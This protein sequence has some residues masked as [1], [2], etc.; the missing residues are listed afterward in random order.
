M[1]EESTKDGGDEV[2][3]PMKGPNEVISLVENCNEEDDDDA[4][5]TATES[6]DDDESGDENSQYSYEDDNDGK[7]V[8]MPP[9]KYARIMGSL[10]RDSASTSTALT[11]KITCSAM[12]RVVVRPS[13]YSE[14]SHEPSLPSGSKHGE[15]AAEWTDYDDD[16]EA[17]MSLTKVHHVLAF[18]F[19]DG[20]VRLV[21]ALTGGSVLFGSSSGDGGAWFVNPAAAKR[22]YDPGHKIV[23]LSFDSSSSYLS[24]LNANGDA[25]IFGPLVW[26]KQSQRAQ[27]TVSGGEGQQRLGFLAS[28][29]GKEPEPTN[30]SDGARFLRPAFT[31][32]KPPAS[33]VRCTYA[34][35]Q[36]FGSSILGGG[37]SGGGQGYH[38]TCMAL[39]PSYGRRKE[40]ALIVGF[41]DG[42]LILSKLQGA[43]G[44]G[45]GITSL[46]GGGGSAA[47]GG[48]TVKKVDSVL[49]QGM[50]STSF[51]GD[52]AG[53]EAVTWR[54][55][56][57]AWAD[58]SG[59]RLFD[60]E[61]MSRIAH[62]DKPTGAR[63]SLYPTISSLH[64]S[65][66]FER[67]DLLLI[68]WG[69]CLMALRV[70]DTQSLTAAT[71]D[72]APAKEIKRKTVEATMAWELDCVACSV[73]P[74]DKQ[75]VAVLGL[76]PS[77]SS[78][79]D[80]DESDQCAKSNTPV[81]DYSV[82]GGD[83]VLELQIINRETGKSI[84]NDRL[85]LSEGHHQSQGD[86]L[87]TTTNATEF[88]LLSSFTCPRMDGVAE[89]EALDDAEK[90]AIGREMGDVGSQSASGKRMPDLHLRWNLGKDV[91]SVGNEIQSEAVH[92]DDD[93][94]VAS[95]CSV[96]S[97]N[98]LF[99]LSEP[100]GD[101]LPDSALPVRS[102][103]PIMTVVYSYDACLVQARD[104][105]DVISYTRA[106]GKPALALKTALAHRRDVRRHGLDQLVDE[107][108]VAL[109]RMGSRG[110]ERPLSFSR[111]KIAAESL[112]IL[113]GGDSRM[114]QRWIFMFSRIRGGLFLIREKIPVRDP[115]LPAFVFEMSLEK[116]L[117]ETLFNFNGQEQQ[118]KDNG[119][120]EKMADL[121]LETIRSWG[122]T[123]ALRR[124]IQLYRYCAQNQQWGLQWHS[125][126]G[127]STVV[128]FIQQAEKDLHRRISQTAFGVLADKHHS[129]SLA[130]NNS[131]RQ[132]IDSSKDSLFDVEHLIT[133]LAM[134][135]HLS[136]TGNSRSPDNYE[137]PSNVILGDMN[138]NS[139]V[140]VESMAELELMRERFDRALGYYLA[141]GSHFMIDSLSSL[142][143][144]AVQ[145]V[146][147]F[148]QNSFNSSTVDQGNKFENDK[149]GHVLSLIELHQLSHV[150]LNR[151]F[152]FSNEKEDSAAESPI[153]ALI[154]L[155]G[156]S[157]AG[158]FLID[159]CSPP[160]GMVRPTDSDGNT[161]SRSSLPLDLVA[162]QL[163]SRPKLL[164]WFL[165]QVFIHKADIYVRFPTTAVPPAA[166]TDLHRIQTSLFVDY[167]DENEAK[168]SENK[169]SPAGLT[170][171]NDTP[172][173]A[174][175]RAAL[176]YGGVQAD[177]VRVK[178]ETYRG[179]IADSPVFARELAFVIEHFGKGTIEDAKEILQLYVRGANNLYM[180][181]EFAE[182]N[183]EHS[184]ILWD[185]L[186]QHCTTPDSTSDTNQNSALGALFG[187]L[188][189][190]AAHTGSDL[191]SLVSRIP[192]G[193]A[194]EGLRP[195]LIAAISDYRY[196]VKIHEHVD[197]M[198][199]EDKISVLRELSHIS[200]RGE[201]MVC[202]Q[203][204]TGR[205]SNQL[206]VRRLKIPPSRQS[207]AFSLPIR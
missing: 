88:S 178:L 121:F 46:F 149:Y 64:P 148:Y 128:S 143:E 179:G 53:I 40:R 72:G 173:M 90:E 156:L 165:F 155:V 108:F 153:V 123:S 8:P 166:I 2:K 18:G 142:E 61:S 44:I 30:A 194:I 169:H 131:I 75:H 180:A 162:E 138:N 16:E 32:V 200:R 102:P 24:A 89:W 36:S 183:I 164:Y 67:S 158:R 150:L 161:F 10:P 22:G 201:R 97:D 28:L 42:R 27:S 134:R 20:K 129:P 96:C 91:C 125:L 159:N 171:D 112:P 17:D 189:E 105:D 181:V 51:S 110:K 56:L 23:A 33:T 60:I 113:L 203:K 163:K 39:D 132:Y 85:P 147:S 13:Q 154:L 109:L 127:G 1:E 168:P 188:L 45:S 21:D 167:A 124:R 7:P 205:S 12:G 66:L 98:Y 199:V 191:A 49:Y 202:H 184:I 82:A 15:S 29:V 70:R 63:S 6:Y 151:N 172:F 19:E 187:S 65:I 204:T 86:N 95:N 152:F 25:A 177:N 186:V 146:N 106:L 81:H 120:V 117:E 78:S 4:D 176:P 59:V 41:D 80:M 185:I 144:M 99:V 69:D 71:K 57:V 114:W 77:P 76:V 115:D 3:D 190:A 58:S 197:N 5:D 198:L 157:R 94:S 195:K 52:Q 31:L 100:I 55:G 35:P 135:L 192:S 193:Y 47:G 122:P 206:K 126:S 107:Y 79:I 207:R 140:I 118:G 101:I 84:S 43:A 139:I 196:K 9:L 182:R 136:D 92:Y 50:G 14:K 48:T 170:A 34:D 137:S 130:Q 68:G 73:V 160:E 74:V 62:I 37:S 174:F 175:L 145:S 11:S 133:R 111:L 83:N 38:P 141:I 116:M 26:G 104:V 87:I 103:P 54:G 119:V 93:Q